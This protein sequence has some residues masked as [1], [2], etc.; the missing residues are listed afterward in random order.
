M[1]GVSAA[2]ATAEPTRADLSAAFNL[3]GR[4]ALVTGAATGVGAAIA[5]ALAAAGATVCACDAE[6]ADD[7]AMQSLT[8][9]LKESGGDHQ[10]VRSDVGTP[11][12]AAAVVEACRSAGRLDIVVTATAGVE[13]SSALAALTHGH[14]LAT[15]DATLTSA[16]LVTHG[17]EPL[18]AR[19]ASIVY[20]GST[21]AT[22]GQ[23]QA[24]AE[25][26]AAAGLIGLTRSLAKELGP[27][28]V[29]VNLVTVA[30]AL[31][32]QAAHLVGVVLFLASAESR[33]ITGEVVVVDGAA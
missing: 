29:R 1:P 14:W 31:L 16:M 23:E 26:A 2:P 15:V 12:G 19:D 6:D 13:R 18:L 21:W 3:S 24:S 5:T 27:R 7:E 8:R 20:I 22:R 9:D 25:A 30:P 17:V 4:R 33:S 11:A 32:A 10:V 28:G